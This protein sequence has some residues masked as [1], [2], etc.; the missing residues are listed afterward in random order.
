MSRIWE[1]QELQ[2]DHRKKIKEVLI[3]L[4]FDA[5]LIED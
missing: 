1:M 5:E 3:K 4:G 2:G